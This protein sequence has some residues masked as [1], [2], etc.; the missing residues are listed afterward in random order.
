[1]VARWWFV[2][3][4]LAGAAAYF[5]WPRTPPPPDHIEVSGTIEATQVDVASKV[6]GRIR[7]I[8]VREGDEVR[9]GQVVAELEAEELEAQL[10]QARAN[11]R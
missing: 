2:P 4:L 9:P 5:L 7:R 1:M 11:L 8:L 3:T 6:A 10:A